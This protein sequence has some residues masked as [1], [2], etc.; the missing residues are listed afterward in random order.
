MPKIKL[1]VGMFERYEDWKAV[2]QVL[3]LDEWTDWIEVEVHSVRYGE[4]IYTLTDEGRRSV[5]NRKSREE[6]A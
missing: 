4:Y 3:G 2:L 5:L 6:S 1:E